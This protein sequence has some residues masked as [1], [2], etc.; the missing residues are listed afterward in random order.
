M[1][2]PSDDAHHGLQARMN[3]SDRRGD[4]LLSNCQDL[5]AIDLRGRH[6]TGRVL[7]PAMLAD[8][9]NCQALARLLCK[10]L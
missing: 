1:Q 5:T 7:H 8:I 6:V 10:D 9:I 3:R 4:V 2:T